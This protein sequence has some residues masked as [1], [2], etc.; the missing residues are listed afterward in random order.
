MET[1]NVLENSKKKLNSKNC[2]MICANSLRKVG[3]GFGV[4]TNVI[5]LITNDGIKELELMKKEDA[6]HEILDNL[7]KIK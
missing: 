4:D 7:T 1:D 5:T 6:A 3:A 2:D